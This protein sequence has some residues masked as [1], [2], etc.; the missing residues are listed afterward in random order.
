[1]GS[2]RADHAGVIVTCSACGRPNRLHF[3]AISR[4][5][6]CG[7]CKEGVGPVSTPVEITDAA[8]FDAAS[9]TSTLPLIVDFWAPWCGPCRMVAP[10]LE[11]VARDTAGRFLVVKVNTDQVTDVAAR[12][13]IQSIPTLAVVWK[14]RELDRAAGARGAADILAFAEHAVAEHERRAS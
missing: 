1:V 11:R 5:A 8:S 2:T 7:Q 12:F 9:A 3:G 13:R 10:E 4:Q 14:G 6:R